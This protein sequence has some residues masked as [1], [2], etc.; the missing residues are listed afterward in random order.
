MT[1]VAV[2]QIGG[3]WI[4]A[5][6]KALKQRTGSNLKFNYIICMAASAGN[7]AVF[8]PFLTE[9]AIAPRLY[10]LLT[11]KLVWIIL[12]TISSDRT[13]GFLRFAFFY[14]L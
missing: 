6:L 8:F 3:Q 2:K 13:C 11:P 1:I 5:V 7:K 14:V 12:I 9:A 10:I 4:A